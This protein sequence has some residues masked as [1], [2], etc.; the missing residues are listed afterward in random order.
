[1]IDT[2]EISGIVWENVTFFLFE[3]YKHHSFQDSSI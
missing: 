3:E 2:H 1:M